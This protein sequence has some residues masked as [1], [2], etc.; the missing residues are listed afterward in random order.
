MLQEKIIRVDEQTGAYE[1]ASRLWALA[2]W[3]RFV[4]PGAVRIGTNGG[5]G[6]RIAAFKNVDESIA[7]V[8]I[9]QGGGGD[10]TISAGDVAPAGG[11][12]KAWASDGERQCEET[13]VAGDGGEVVVNVAANSITTVVFAAAAAEVEEPAE[14]SP[15]EDVPEE[16]DVGETP[17]EE[18]GAA[19]EEP[20][21]P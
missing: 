6:V 8:L 21:E 3:S 19:V 1:V 5:Q 10:I 7:V 15:V 14:E 2:N 16:T 13:E 12:V 17:P 4:R 20:T 9:S 18:T 11:V